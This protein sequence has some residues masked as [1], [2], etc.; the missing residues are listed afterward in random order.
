MIIIAH[1]VIALQEIFV[2]CKEIDEHPSYHGTMT[3][4]LAESELLRQRAKS[5]TCYLIRYCSSEKSYKLSVLWI[6][7]KKNPK[8]KHFLIKIEDGIVE[9][10]AEEKFKHVSDM[11]TFYQN[12]SNEFDRIGVGVTREKY[13]QNVS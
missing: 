6:R 7:D 13:E 9:C 3:E 1:I 11:L 5:C 10:E 12:I 8:Y 4:S 2:M